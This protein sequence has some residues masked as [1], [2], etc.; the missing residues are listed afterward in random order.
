[1]TQESINNIINIAT[2]A[3]YGAQGPKITLPTP[4]VEILTGTVV[5]H[6]Y[7]KIASS[8]HP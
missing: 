5:T 6:C 4:L 1:M 7:N 3:V 8:S 2:V